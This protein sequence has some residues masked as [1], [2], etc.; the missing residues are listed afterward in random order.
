M[1]KKIKIYLPSF[2]TNR[3]LDKLEFIEETADSIDSSTNKSRFVNIPANSCFQNAYI[4]PFYLWK[5]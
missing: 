3:C 1:L 2:L 4:Y 5:T